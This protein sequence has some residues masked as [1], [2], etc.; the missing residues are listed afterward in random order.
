MAYEDKRSDNSGP[1]MLSV[2]K[3]S[4]PGNRITQILKRFNTVIEDE[5]NTL[6]ECGCIEDARDTGDVLAAILENRLRGAEEKVTAESPHSGAL[7]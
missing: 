1:S 6:E 3:S 4:R 5:L 2:C 7:H